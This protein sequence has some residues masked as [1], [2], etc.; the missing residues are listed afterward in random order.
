M[1]LVMTLVAVGVLGFA[2]GL[3]LFRVK[4]RWCPQCGARLGCPDCR[5]RVPHPY[6]RNSRPGGWQ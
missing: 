5:G 2:A 4:S 6:L 3:F 1:R